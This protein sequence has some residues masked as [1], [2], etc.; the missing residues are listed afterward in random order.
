MEEITAKL[1]QLEHIKEQR[2]KASRDYYRKWVKPE[3]LEKLTEEDR[4]KHEKRRKKHNDYAK[5]YYQANKEKILARL[6]EKRAEE[7]AQKSTESE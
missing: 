7:K 6:A 2:R 3:N 4:V 5:S 1:E